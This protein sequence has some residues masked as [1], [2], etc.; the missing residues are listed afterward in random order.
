MKAMNQLYALT[1][2]I[3]TPKDTILDQIYEIL[4]SGIRFIQLRDKT[5][6]DDELIPLAKEMKKICD[7]F[8][9][10]LIINDRISL[11]KQINAHGLHIGKD[12]ISLQLARKALPKAYIGISCYDDINLAKN[13]QKN[14]ADYVAFGAMFQSHTKKT[15]KPIDHRIISKAKKLSIPICVIGGINEQNIH[16]IKKLEPNLIALVQAIYKPNS[17]KNNIHTLS[18]IL[19]T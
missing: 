3:L 6:N 14:G 2:E 19:N 16:Q 4:S 12:D 11:A 10:K 5:S 18:E 9:A 7:K 15:A 8:D 13:A 17:I 1:D